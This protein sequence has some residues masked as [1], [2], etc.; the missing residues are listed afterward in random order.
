MQEMLEAETKKL[1]AE[2]GLET[3]GESVDPVSGNEVPPGSLPEEVRDDVDAKLS[4][5]EYVIPA[6]VV[7][8]FGV[9]YFE[10]LR[11]KAKEGMMSMQEDGRIGG[12]DPEAEMEEEGDDLPFDDEE[13]EFEDDE[14][15]MAEGG[16]VQPSFNPSDF[17]YGSGDAGIQTKTY[18]TKDGKRMSV[19]FIDG[20]PMTKVPE[21]YFPEG[22]VPKDDAVGTGEEVKKPEGFGDSRDQED[23]DKPQGQTA[24]SPAELSNEELE[25]EVAKIKKQSEFTDGLS[26]VAGMIGGPFG[27]AIK[28][29]YNNT[30]KLYEDE[31]AKRA[32]AGTLEKDKATS[33]TSDLSSSRIGEKKSGGGIGGFVEKLFGLGGDDEVSGSPR[34]DTLGSQGEQR[35]TPAGDFRGPNT[36]LGFGSSTPSTSTPSAPADTRGVGGTNTSLG[37]GGTTGGSK[38]TTGGGGYN[39]GKEED[40]EDKSVG[41]GYS[42]GTPETTSGYGGGRAK[43]GLVSERKKC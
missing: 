1:F 34:G 3:S 29:G 37:Y 40:E 12:A 2:G 24:K 22:S 21:G 27:L 39:L 35:D 15:E 25:A 4:D 41:G 30:L 11:K 6:D 31:V 10:K 28:A 16:V 33:F 9:A 18:V 23:R 42:L 14:V 38:P 20:T 26:K 7:R 19:L 17:A 8:F 5:G 32:E 36:S 43:G 13:L